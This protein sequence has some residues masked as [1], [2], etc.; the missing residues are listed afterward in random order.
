MSF[1]H[2]AREIVVQALFAW[3]MR[4][5]EPDQQQEHFD[6]SIDRFSGKIPDQDFPSSLYNGV[7]KKID[8]ID[9]IIGKAAG[10]RGITGDQESGLALSRQPRGKRRPALRG[11]DR[12]GEMLAQ[13]R[14]D[15]CRQSACAEV[16]EH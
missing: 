16:G 4:G 2:L 7:I 14:A 15:A 9:D 13:P 1:R 12:E 3:D 6:F 5:Q 10:A 8:V 11:G